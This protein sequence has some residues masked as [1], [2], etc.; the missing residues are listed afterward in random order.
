MEIAMR[1]SGLHRASSMHDITG[2]PH[3]IIATRCSGLHRASSMHDKSH[4]SYFSTTDG[5]VIYCCVLLF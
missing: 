2:T 5:C 1:C 3:M 4:Q